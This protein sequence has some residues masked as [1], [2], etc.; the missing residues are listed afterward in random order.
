M[1]ALALTNKLIQTPAI[2]AGYIGTV[3]T[4]RKPLTDRHGVQIVVDN[5]MRGAIRA[6]ICGNAAMSNY[7]ALEVYSGFV[8]DA[9]RIVTG[10]SPS[11]TVV[12]Q[13]VD[14]ITTR[15]SNLT[16]FD[17][18]YDDR[19]NTFTTLRN[20]QVVGLSWVDATNI[21]THGSSKRF[22]GIVSNAFNGTAPGTYGFGIKKVTFYDW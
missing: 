4:P 22:V 7:G 6:W 13:Q 21:V 5:K 20:G 16:T 10:A 9:M 14:C 1:T 3:G 18:R 8:G 17:I 2:S 19:N 11:L 15:L 12:Q